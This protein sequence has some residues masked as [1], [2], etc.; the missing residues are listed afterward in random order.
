M[1][2]ASLSGMSLTTLEIPWTT[3]K[4]VASTSKTKSGPRPIFALARPLAFAPINSTL[5]L[6]ACVEGQKKFA[7]F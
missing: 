3:S 6:S 7:S 2:T 1:A 5:I 4:S